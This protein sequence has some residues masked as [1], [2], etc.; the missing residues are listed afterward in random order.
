MLKK[1]MKKIGKQL[2]DMKNYKIMK[3]GRP[4]Y[5][6]NKEGIIFEH[7]TSKCFCPL[8]VLMCE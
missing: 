8:Y 6:N 3:S 4:E 7:S 2:K 1:I 5:N